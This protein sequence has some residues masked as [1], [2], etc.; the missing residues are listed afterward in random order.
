MAAP[1][2]LYSPLNHSEDSKAPRRQLDG[3]VAPATD[4]RGGGRARPGSPAAGLSWLVGRPDGGCPA[5]R[6]AWH[7]AVGR[8][9][10]GR[11]CQD[12][13]HGVG[14][15]PRPPCGVRSAVPSSG[16]GGPAVRCP[17]GG[18]QCS[19]CP[20]RPVSGR[21]VSTRPVSSRLLSASV[22]PDASISSHPR[23]RGPGRGDGQPLPQERVESRWAAASWS[24]S[25]DGRAGPD[26]RRGC[27]GRVR[28][29]GSVADP[30]Q[31]G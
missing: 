14:A 16:S 10:R 31:V 3:G 24:G 28:Q 6:P 12:A 11:Q 15:G 2:P 17:A 19:Q 7:P 30:G 5:E 27:R 1:V 25:M 8:C 9:R 4:G 23:R 21:P 22:G 29:W 13:C 18:V 20:A 26:A